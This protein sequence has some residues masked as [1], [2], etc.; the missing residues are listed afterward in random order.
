M[1]LKSINDGEA[2]GGKWSLVEIS[3]ISSELDLPRGEQ[4]L[5]LF[6]NKKILIAF[7]RFFYKS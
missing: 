5:K 6:E 4:C 7:Q 1:C 3:V 2:L